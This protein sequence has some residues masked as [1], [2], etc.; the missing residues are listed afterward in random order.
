MARHYL[1]PDRRH[2]KSRQAHLLAAN[3]LAA[4]FSGPRQ[5]HLSAE[6]GRIGR[7]RQS[8]HSRTA[9]HEQLLQRVRSL[10]RIR[11]RHHPLCVDHT[12]MTHTH[13]TPPVLE[14]N[15][16]TEGPCKSCTA[17]TSVPLQ[18]A[19]SPPSTKE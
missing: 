6:R 3:L 8:N 4:R 11:Q 19:P 10:P 7:S 16:A 9:A 2:R 5:I 13:P 1:H 12:A 18:L 17:T 15:S 14:A